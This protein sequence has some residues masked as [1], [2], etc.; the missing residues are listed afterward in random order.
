MAGS[1]LYAA[2]A[3]SQLGAKTSILAPLGSEDRDL[4]MALTEE[5]G[6]A[7]HL[8][9]SPGASA[10]FAYETRGERR[11]ARGY[12]P[13]SSR[14]AVGELPDLGERPSVVLIFGHPEWD[15]CTSEPLRDLTVGSTLLFDRQGWMSATPRATDAF[16]LPAALRISLTNAGELDEEGSGKT[17]PWES[18]PLNGF[19]ASV[20]KDGPW[21]THLFEAGRRLS[22]PAHTINPI[23]EI[24]SGDVFAGSLAASLAAG[25]LL[26]SGCPRA[27]AA[28]AVSISTSEPLPNADFSERVAELEADPKLRPPLPPSARAQAALVIEHPEGPLGESF[29]QTLRARLFEYG[30]TRA[31]YLATADPVPAVRLGEHRKPLDHSLERSLS[32]LLDWLTGCLRERASQA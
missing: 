4:A 30:F 28:A 19:D 25:D 12:R 32:D 31:E 26:E 20:V 8:L 17:V 18:L 27:V 2:G 6:I 3:A 10:T 23:D 21:G 24:G 1:A 15:P 5:A 13:A 11:V 9:E 22:F 14:P 29:A 7:A 16:S